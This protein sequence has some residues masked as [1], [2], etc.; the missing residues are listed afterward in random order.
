MRRHPHRCAPDS[1]ETSGQT[2][3]TC[4]QS[5]GPERQILGNAHSPLPAQRRYS[6]GGIETSNAVAAA[7]AARRPRPS[8]H[9]TP[10]VRSP[11]YLESFV[12]TAINQNTAKVRREK[13]KRKKKLNVRTP[14]RFSRCIKHG[15]LRRT[16]SHLRVNPMHSRGLVRFL[17]L[18]FFPFFLIPLRQIVPPVCTYLP[19][20]FLSD[21]RNAI[22]RK[23]FPPKKK[24]K[25]RKKY[26][27]ESWRS[28]F[29]RPKVTPHHPAV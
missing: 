2:D 13:K 15:P 1:T 9:G 16:Q 3:V 10:G 12:R 29:R 24:K 21:R 11:R 22:M 19:T 28:L 4:K 26:V 18:F 14:S 5:D 25:T 20:K 23:H 17:F 7:R 6:Y 8:F 27:L